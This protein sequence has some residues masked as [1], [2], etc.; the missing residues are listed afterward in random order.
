MREKNASAKKVKG[1]V[2]LFRIGVLCC[3]VGLVVGLSNL[4]S[5]QNEYDIGT[6]VY[7]QLRQEYLVS[8]QSSF[9]KKQDAPSVSSQHSD[10]VWKGDESGEIQDTRVVDFAALKEINADIA[11]W[12]FCADTAIDYPV[13]HGKDNE[14]Y[15]THLFTGEKNAA[16]SIFLDYRN[17]PDF[18]DRHSVIYGHNMKNGTMFASLTKYR[19]PEYFYDHPEIFFYT[20]EKEYS[21]KI[22]SGYSAGLE[23]EAWRLG[24]TSD[25]DFEAWVLQEKEKS[26][27]KSEVEP[28]AEDR[29]V[30]LSTCI[31][32][33]EDKRFIIHGILESLE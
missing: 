8:S 13:V 21:I 11:A 7:E 6:N 17:N 10:H 25:E 28:S 32:E 9:Q 23:D 30:T 14:Y 4:W 2:W 16:G 12:I 20:L 19:N 15:L 5:I 26:Y 22:F 3:I 33:N 18:S 29:I 1:T 31:N 24:F 27:F